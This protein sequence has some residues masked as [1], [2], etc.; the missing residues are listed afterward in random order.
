MTEYAGGQN[1]GV[2]G[3]GDGGM[4]TIRSV[5][6]VVRGKG[7]DEGRGVMAL[8]EAHMQ[9]DQVERPKWSVLGFGVGVRYEYYV[10]C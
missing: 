9:S 6:R 10:Q 1:G 8:K 4:G 2:V 3:V 7:G 5:V